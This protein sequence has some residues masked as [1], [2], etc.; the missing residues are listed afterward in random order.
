MR[1]SRRQLSLEMGGGESAGAGGGVSSPSG[2]RERVMRMVEYSPFPRVSPDPETRCGFTRDLSSSG[3]CLGTDHAEPVGAVLR[4]VVCGVDG[5][6]TLECLAR[7]VWRRRRVDGRW[8][9]GLERVS[10]GRRLMK[11]RRT[12]HGRELAETA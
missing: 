8:W 6:P 5:R 9:L 10:E 1:E 11:V 2:R 7:V 12:S 4:A 3:M